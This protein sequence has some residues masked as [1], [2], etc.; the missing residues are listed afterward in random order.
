MQKYARRMGAMA[1]VDVDDVVR[2]SADCYADAAASRPWPAS[3][4]WWTSWA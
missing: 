1:R 3:P 2:A 4:R